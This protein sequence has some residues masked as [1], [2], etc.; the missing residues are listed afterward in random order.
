MLEVHSP[1]T[2][3]QGRWHQSNRYHREDLDDLALVQTN[4]ANRSIHQEVNLVK[5]E[6]GVILK[7]VNVAQNLTRFFLLLILE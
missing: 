7:G 1:N 6:C 5:Q 2:G 4:K 3:E